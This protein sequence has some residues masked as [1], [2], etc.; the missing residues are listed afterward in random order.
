MPKKAVQELKTQIKRV[1]SLGVPFIHDGM[2]YGVHLKKVYCR[3]VDKFRVPKQVRILEGTEIVFPHA[4]AETTVEEVILPHTLESIGD[5]AFMQCSQLRTIHGGGDLNTL[6]E[7]AFAYCPQLRELHLNNTCKTTII[8]TQLCRCDENL[9]EVWLPKWTKAILE[10]AFLGCTNLHTV[11][12]PDTHVLIAP[13][14][15]S[16]DCRTELVYYKQDK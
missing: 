2:Q 15:F 10:G 7:W 14:V 6:G 11:H 13:H 9:R 1:E 4:F 3:P 8:P 16:E 5:S 12:L